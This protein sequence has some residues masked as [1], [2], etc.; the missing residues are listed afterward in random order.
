MRGKSIQFV[1][2]AFKAALGGKKVLVCT[3]QGNVKMERVPEPTSLDGQ[4]GA[5]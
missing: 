4:T 5:H 3:A 1:L 2:D